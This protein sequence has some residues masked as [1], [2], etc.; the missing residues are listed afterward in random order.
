MSHA[1]WTWSQH[2]HET[3][4]T[5]ATGW[6]LHSPRRRSTRGLARQWRA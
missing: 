4:A 3:E 5:S 1:T 2:A 6:S